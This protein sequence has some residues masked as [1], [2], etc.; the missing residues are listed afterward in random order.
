ML[1]CYS[2]WQFQEKILGL[3]ALHLPIQILKRIVSIVNELTYEP[4]QW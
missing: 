3:H 4:W 1:I 2:S